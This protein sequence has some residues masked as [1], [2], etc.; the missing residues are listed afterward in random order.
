MSMQRHTRPT[1]RKSTTAD[2]PKIRSGI[3]CARPVS[4]DGRPRPQG[5]ARDL[6]IANIEALLA[7]FESMAAKLQSLEVDLHAQSS[8][9]Q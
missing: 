8:A 7:R 4:L 5:A 1:T 6:L 3:V 2:R 9:P